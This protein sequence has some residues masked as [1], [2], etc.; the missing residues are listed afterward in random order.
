[1]VFL[2]TIASNNT[3]I[4]MPDTIDMTNIE[5]TV[6][7]FHASIGGFSGDVFK[8]MALN[9]GIAM[10]RQSNGLVITGFQNLL[11]G[12]KG[13]VISGLRNKSI[14]GAGLQIGLFNICKHLKGVQIGLW[15]VNSKR[16]LPFIN[17]DFRSTAKRTRQ[18]QG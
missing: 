9:G 18:L 15:N 7:G 13:V 17:W 5:T 2:F 12:F 8:G 11:D 16:K 6:H 14:K 4:N 1:M 3:L 10:A